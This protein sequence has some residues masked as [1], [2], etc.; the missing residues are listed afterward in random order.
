[1]D[2]VVLM[3]NALATPESMKMNLLGFSPIALVVLAQRLK[4]GLV[5]LKEQ[6][7]LTLLL[8]APTKVFATAPLANAN[9]SRT[10][11]VLPANAPSAPMVA[12]M[13]VFVLLKSSLLLKLIVSTLP[14][15]MRRNMW[16]ASAILVVVVLIALLSSAPL[17]LM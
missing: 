5:F 10:M 3:I 17:V 2:R 9:A 11:M 15:G 1:M 4:H 14:H 12:M 8:N 13:P 6:M 16:D 7:M